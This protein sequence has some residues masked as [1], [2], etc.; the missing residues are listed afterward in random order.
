MTIV[1]SFYI[2]FCYD[3]LLSLKSQLLSNGIQKGSGSGVGKMG[4]SESSR[5]RGNCNQDI[6]YEKFFNK[7]GKIIKR[8]F[9][10]C[11]SSSLS[12]LLL[13]LV[14]KIKHSFFFV[15]MDIKP[16]A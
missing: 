10:A 8:I 9:I 11:F 6:I 7:S 13:H 14:H 12:F 4:G 1:L 5:W 16:K 15:V 3:L 2:L